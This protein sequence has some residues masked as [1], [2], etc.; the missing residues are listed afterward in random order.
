MTITADPASTIDIRRHNF[1]GSLDRPALWKMY[2]ATFA[3]IDGLAV[4]RHLMTST[5]FHAVMID[6]DVRKHLAYDGDRPRDRLVGQSV[7]TN[8]LD[9]WPL[10]S[11]RYFARRWPDLYAEKRIFYIGYV[12][13]VK[14][15]P[16]HTFRALISDMS[17]EVFAADGMCVMD[18]C[19][20]NVAELRMPT[21]THALL[22]H[23]HPAPSSPLLVDE[24]QW[25][26]WR[27]DGRQW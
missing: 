11:P 20:H 18:F 12:G 17:R 14:D 8:N 26:A 19:A 9:A 2:E 22:R 3:E 13:T 6:S 10:I 7:I 5:E 21:R 1:V 25:W 24:Q 15:A 23:L 27:F 4:Q 16:A